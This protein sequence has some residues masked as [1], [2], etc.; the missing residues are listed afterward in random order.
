MPLQS[1]IRTQLGRE[2]FGAGMEA[3]WR[4]RVDEPDAFPPEFWKPFLQSNPMAP[5]REMPPG[6]R[7]DDTEAP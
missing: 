1:M 4:R 5:G 2:H 7:G 6:L 3:F